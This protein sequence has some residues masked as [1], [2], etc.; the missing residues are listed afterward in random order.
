MNLQ[1]E[2]DKQIYERVKKEIEEKENK[3]SK[4]KKLPVSLIIIF[5]LIIDS[6]VYVNKDIILDDFFASGTEE[7][8]VVI[9]KNFEK[10]LRLSVLN[11]YDEAIP[12]FEKLNFNKLKKEDKEIILNVYIATNEIKHLQKV[13]DLDDTKDA[14]IVESLLNNDSLNKLKEL[15]TE[16]ELIT[17]EIAVQENDYE[18]I[19]DLKDDVELDERRANAIANAYYQLDEKE[20]AVSFSSLM[21]HDDI[22]VWKENK[23][24]SS[25]EII[26]TELNKDTSNVFLF[27]LLV[28]GL[29]VVMSLLTVF[30]WKKKDTIIQRFRKEKNREI[31]TEEKDEISEEKYI[32]HYEDY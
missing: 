23:D 21:A 5:T 2:R 25:Q 14:D 31:N 8:E 17:F 7:N 13:L 16:S 3:R 26:V 22:N 12:H 27:V 19:I 29:V 6:F 11:R 24:S 10:G 1:S 28:I 15:E 18:T 9:N 30:I 32:Y 4:N 20:K